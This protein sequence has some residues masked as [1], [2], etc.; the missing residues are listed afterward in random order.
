M[1]LLRLLEQES[2][3]ES[4]QVRQSFRLL[5]FGLGVGATAGPRG[6]I[7]K[8]RA[9]EHHV[10]LLQSHARRLLKITV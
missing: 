2:N 4:K 1:R 7:S 8:Q 10:T 6:G 5:N 3:T 9:A